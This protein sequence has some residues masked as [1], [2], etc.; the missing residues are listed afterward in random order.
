MDELPKLVMIDYLAVPEPEEKSWKT[1][2]LRNKVLY[3]CQFE[4]CLKDFTRLYNLKSHYRSHTGERP[5]VS[6]TC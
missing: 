2:K 3:Q 1:I 5:Y 6:A 4:G